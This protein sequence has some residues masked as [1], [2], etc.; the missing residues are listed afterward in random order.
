MAFFDLAACDTSERFVLGVE[1][2]CRSFM[3]AADRF[4][5]SSYLNN[6]TAWSE[7]AE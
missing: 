4:V 2:D 1:A 3:V 7:V 6:S 5:Y